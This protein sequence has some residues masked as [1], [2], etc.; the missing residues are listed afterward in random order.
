MGYYDCVLHI[1]ILIIILLAGQ[2]FYFHTFLKLDTKQA[3][4]IIVEKPWS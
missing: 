2:F 4:H 3:Q 1:I